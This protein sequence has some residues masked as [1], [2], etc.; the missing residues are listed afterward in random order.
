LVPQF[1]LAARSLVRR[2]REKGGTAV[3][4]AVAILTAGTEIPVMVMGVVAVVTA[5]A[6]GTVPAV[7]EAMSARET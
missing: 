5:M 7:A 6:T 1:G 3:R 4:V 2:P